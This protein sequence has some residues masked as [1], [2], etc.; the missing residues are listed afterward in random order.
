MQEQEGGGV[1][2]P[3]GQ[4]MPSQTPP[5]RIPVKTLLFGESGNT[6]PVT[7]MT[8]QKSWQHKFPGRVRPVTR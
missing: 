2:R 7:A 8:L 3:G 4:G 6:H 1:P 5:P